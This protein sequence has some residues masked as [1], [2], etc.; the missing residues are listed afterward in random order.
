MQIYFSQSQQIILLIINFGIISANIGGFLFLWI[1]VIELN[2]RMYFQVDYLGYLWVLVFF[3]LLNYS[4][5]SRFARF[6]IIFEFQ[7]GA[8][9]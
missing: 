1:L 5:L 9:N 6:S 4:T 2:N 8:R 3:R 7:S